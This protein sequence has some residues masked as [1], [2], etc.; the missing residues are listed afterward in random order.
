M[1]HA[2]GFVAAALVALGVAAK[3]PPPNDEAKAKAAETAAKAK[4]TDSVGAYQLCKS[5]DRVV[6]AYRARESRVASEVIRGFSTRSTTPPTTDSEGI[7]Q[8]DLARSEAISF[9]ASASM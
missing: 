9:R 8:V 3:L 6:A 2:L 4:W 7:V 5:Q 1:K